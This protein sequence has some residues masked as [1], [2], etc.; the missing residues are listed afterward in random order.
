MTRSYATI[1][2]FELAY[3]VHGD[4]RWPGVVLSH[5]LATTMDLWGYQLP[6]LASRYRVVLY[7]LRGHGKSGDPGEQ[8]TLEALASD[9]AALLDHLEIRRATFVGLSIG[10]MIGQ[11]LAVQY[12]DKIIGLVLCST[13]GRTEPPA[14]IAAVSSSTPASFS[15][16]PAAPAARA[17]RT[18]SASPKL[19]RTM[20]TTSG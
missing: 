9:A 13:G 5:A 7:D 3:S 8:Y 17:A 6:L 18:R 11:H 16:S 15:T 12:P 1:N 10:G 19:V 4:A 20:T 14:R 2:G